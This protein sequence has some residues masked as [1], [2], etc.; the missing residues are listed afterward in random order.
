M[1]LP[2]FEAYDGHALGK[3]SHDVLF[4]AH[5]VSENGPPVHDRFRDIVQLLFPPSVC[6][7]STQMLPA[8]IHQVYRLDLSNGQRLVIK[9]SPPPAVPLLRRER[10]ALE[11]EA[12][13]LNLLASIDGLFMSRLYYFVPYD[14]HLSIPYLVRQHVA[15]IPMTDMRERLSERDL[16]VIDVQLGSLFRKISRKRSETFGPLGKVAAGTGSRHWRE[17]FAS[18]FEEVLRDAEDMLIHLPYSQ[19]RR[20]IHRLSFTLDEVAMP[21]LVV[22][23]FGRPSQVLLNPVTKKVSGISNWGSALWGD[24]MMAE[25]FESPSQAFVA[26]FGSIPEVGRFHSVRALL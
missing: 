26:G 20:E 4:S 2:S 24:P 22:L 25:I 10:T 6:L 8:C 12:R 5:M 14:T 23:D 17:A 16:N 3:S 15:G 18:L 1:R 11:T 21:R 19:I 9:V 13:A 7:N